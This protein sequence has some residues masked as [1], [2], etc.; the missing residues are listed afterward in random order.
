VVPSP[1]GRVDPACNDLGL[2]GYW[3]AVADGYPDRQGNASCLDPGLHQLVDCSVFLT[4]DPGKLEFPNMNGRMFTVGTAAQ[5]VPCVDG[6][7]G[8][9]C[10]SSDYANI[11]GAAIG[12]YFNAGPSG[13]PGA[14]DPDHFGVI[15]VSFTV[16]NLPAAGLR[17]EFPMLLTDAEATGAGLPAGSTT[18]DMND[19]RSPYWGAQ[20]RGDGKFPNSPVIEGENLVYWTDVSPPKLGAYTWDPSRVVGIRF[21]VPA[22]TAGEHAYNFAISNV[23]FR[24][25]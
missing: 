2:D 13:D 11:W 1:T 18:E 10:P 24:R 20:A 17:V 12:F 14:W 19:V 16:E 8:S 25:L 5:V 22:T 7:T 21:L 6:V 15:G 9:G 4:P 23:G 3:F